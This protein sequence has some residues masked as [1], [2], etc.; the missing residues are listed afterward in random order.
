MALFAD[1]MTQAG[2]QR[3]T[4]LRRVNS[5]AVRIE[6]FNYSSTL[7]SILSSTRLI[8]AVA[9]NYRVVQN[10]LVKVKARFDSSGDAMIT[11]SVAL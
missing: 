4:R 10:K 7:S 11:S 8:P 9:I 6:L 1:T 5:R 2:G 3:H